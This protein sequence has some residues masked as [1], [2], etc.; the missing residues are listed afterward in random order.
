[1]SPSA[2]AEIRRQ[3]GWPDNVTVLLHAGNMGVKQGLANVIQ[4]S[5]VAYQKNLPILFVLMG[6]GNQRPELEAMGGNPCVRIIDPVPSESF[7]ST[8]GAADALLVNE[9]GGVTEMSVPSKLTSYFA[10]GLPIIAAT[11]PGSVT[12]QELKMSNAGVRVDADCPDQLVEVA[13]E[14]RNNPQRFAD[15]GMNGPVFRSSHL[16]A[17]TSLA[18][19]HEVLALAAYGSSDALLTKPSASARSKRLIARSN[20][21]VMELAIAGLDK[22]RSGCDGAHLLDEFKVVDPSISART[23]T[24]GHLP[25]SLCRADAS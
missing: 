22:L 11:D 5:R 4:A 13:L 19:F 3:L 2:R 7:A 20:G 24:L 15:L 8:L 23:S 10:T 9:R 21:E 1:M 16:M 6:D 18:S 12:A 14:L 25:K 17:D